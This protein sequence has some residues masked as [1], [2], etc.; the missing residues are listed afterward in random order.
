MKRF[1]FLSLIVAFAYNVNAQITISS[2]NLVVGDSIFQATDTT[3]KTEL[4]AAGGA[5]L[6]WDFSGLLEHN[7]DTIAPIDPT[8]TDHAD[9][10]TNS[11]L[12]FGTPEMAG[13]MQNNTNEYVNLG[14]GGY[15]EQIDADVLMVYSDPDSIIDFPMNY[16][17]SRDV[18]A[19]GTTNLTVQGND[20]R[21]SQ[22][23]FRTQEIDAWGKVTTPKGTFDVIRVNEYLIQ[24]DSVFVIIYGTESYQE[25][26]SSFDT[27]YNYTFY[28]TEASHNFN[29]Y[30]LLEVQY[31]NDADTIIQSKWLTY[32]ENAENVTE[33]FNSE[34]ISVY[35]NP[36]SDIVNIV[37]NEKISSVNIYNT[38]GKIVKTSSKNQ[39]QVSDLPAS[40]YFI[41]VKTK[42]NLY[43]KKIMVK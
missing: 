9:G 20:V 15:V 11:N 34:A 28:T 32:E 22:S 36:S 43:R 16:G 21:L 31:D 42:H 39:I 7:R 1:L 13:Y 40:I 6:S 10:F 38:E 14:F 25:D 12:A 8:E 18:D 29:K 41:E 3:F 33:L 19:Y 27:S 30:P 2:M 5:D 35:P 4:I 37:T 24:I 23:I 17:D 26:Y